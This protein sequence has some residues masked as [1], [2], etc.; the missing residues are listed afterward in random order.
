MLV[1]ARQHCPSLLWYERFVHD[2]RV[3]YDHEQGIKDR[4]NYFV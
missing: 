2:L 4:P 1:I 3:V